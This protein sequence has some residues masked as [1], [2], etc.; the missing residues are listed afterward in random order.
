MSEKKEIDINLIELINLSAKILD[1]LFI[2]GS[3]DKAKPTF[4]VL[5]QGKAYPLGKVTFQDRIESSLNLTM[6]YSEF[7]G[8]GFNYDVFQTAVKGILS[9]IS[10]KFKTKADPNIMSSEDNR[11]FLVNLPGLVELGGQLNALVLAF[12]FNNLEMIN[13]KLMFVDPTQYEAVR[14]DR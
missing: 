8:P 10:L 13:I 11:S 3:K 2:R 6:D 5:K 7:C 14:K 9:Q 1:Q 12:E 4:K